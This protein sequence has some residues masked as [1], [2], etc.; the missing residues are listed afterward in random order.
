MKRNPVKDKYFGSQIKSLSNLFDKH[1]IN[2]GFIEDFYFE[3]KPDA[4]LSLN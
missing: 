2:I 4:D 1:Q 3:F